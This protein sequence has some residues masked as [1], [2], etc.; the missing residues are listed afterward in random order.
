MTSPKRIHVGLN[1]DDLD[2]AIEFYTRLFDQP[3]TMRRDEYVK[4]MLDDPFVNL[5]I[6]DSPDERNGVNHLGI[7][8]PSNDALDAQRTTWDDNGL[9][10]HDQDDLLCGYQHQDKSWVF[11]PEGV[12]W[13]AFVTHGVVDTYGTDDLPDRTES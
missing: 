7:Q 1:V 2:A 6:T 8:V 10:R 3:P 13:E 12:G 4:S 11:D 9:E 5:S